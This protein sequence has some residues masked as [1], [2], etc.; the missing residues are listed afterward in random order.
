MMETSAT[1]NRI[2]VLPY[3]CQY[4]NAPNAPNSYVF[5]RD[6]SEV[7]SD[8]D[9]PIKYKSMIGSFSLLVMQYMLKS[10]LPKETTNILH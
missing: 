3:Y 9:L 6:D 2:F 5:V 4:R 1:I 8:A 7:N 10:S